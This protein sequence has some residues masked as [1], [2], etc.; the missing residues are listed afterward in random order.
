M[1]FSKA[2]TSRINAGLQTRTTR[3]GKKRWELGGVHPVQRGNYGPVVGW[4]RIVALARIRLGTLS[5]Q[6]AV[7]EGFTNL[8]AFKRHWRFL[9]RRWDASLEVWDIRFVMTGRP[10]R[11][12]QQTSLFDEREEQG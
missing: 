5:E 4:V 12:V 8:E 10:E 2:A 1:I 7:A 11:H 9:Y 6:D 3:R